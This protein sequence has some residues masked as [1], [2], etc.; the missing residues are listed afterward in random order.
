LSPIV[1]NPVEKTTRNDE[2]HGETE[3]RNRL[4]VL[5][6]QIDAAEQDD[7]RDKRGIQRADSIFRTPTPALLYTV[8]LV[9][10][11]TAILGSFPDSECPPRSGEIP[12][13]HSGSRKTL[14]PDLPLQISF[15]KEWLRTLRGKRPS[16]GM[17]LFPDYDK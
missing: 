1:L 17:T 8:A 13:A 4:A 9:D 14:H 6:V 12:E 2:G 7:Q 15:R 10:P 11:D 16:G 3:G 5:A